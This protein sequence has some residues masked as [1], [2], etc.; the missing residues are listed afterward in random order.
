MF[1]HD[2]ET[3]TE[4]QAG[5]F[6]DWLGR[7]ERIEDAVRFLDAWSGIREKH[8]DVGAVAHGLDSENAALRGFHGVDGV[9][10]HIEEDLHQLVSIAANAGKN[11]LELKLDADGAGAHVESA[12]LHGIGD[13]GVDVQ[14]RAFR[15]NLPGKAEK[16]SD[17]SFCAASLVANFR[18]RGAGFF[19]KRR[20]IG[21]KIGVAK[22]RRQADC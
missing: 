16:I 9:A 11:G 20:V 1:L 6:A 5:A 18:G 7:I 4:T 22:N 8:D 10:D 14:K 13:H 17:E 12:K 19:G 3:N 15:G 2:A 21:Q